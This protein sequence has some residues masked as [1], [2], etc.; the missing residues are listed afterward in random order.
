M[1]D[2]Y[3]YP[4]H[5]HGPLQICI[6]C[7]GPVFQCFTLGGGF[8]HTSNVTNPEGCQTGYYQNHPEYVVEPIPKS[9]MIETRFA[10]ESPE[11]VVVSE[12]VA[13]SEWNVGDVI[14]D[15]YEIKELIGQGGM[16]KVFKVRHR[17]WNLDLAV[18]SPRVEIFSKQEGKTGFVK[19]AQSWVDLG[20]Y[21]HIVTCYYVRTLGDIPRIF[22]E[23]IDGGSLADWIRS[24]RLYEGGNEKALAR[25][26]DFMIQFVLG[27]HYA[28]E[29]GLIHQDV[30]PANVMIAVDGT[31]KVTDFGLSK[32]RGQ[33]GENQDLRSGQSILVSS[34]GMTPAYCSPEQASG[35]Q[36]SR[37]TDIW[38]WGVSVLEIFTGGVN[39]A[40]GQV[41]YEALESYL[42]TGS[43]GMIPQMPGQLA[44]LLKLCFSRNP[45]D[46]PASMMNIADTLRE[47]YQQLTGVTYPRLEPKAATL[48]ADGLNNKAL[49][50]L[51]L[52]MESS[53]KEI[54]QSALQADPQHPE[55][56]YN[57]G[58]HNWRCGELADDAL[59]QR[60][61]SVQDAHRERWQPAYYT[62]LV[63]LE[64]CDPESAIPLLEA[65][66]RQAGEQPEI[67]AMLK[68]ATSGS[69]VSPR[70]LQKL[71]VHTDYVTS[72]CWSNDRTKIL[73]ASNDRYMKL[74]DLE[75]GE[76][77]RTFFADGDRIDSIS[78]TRDFRF[79][80]TGGEN[81]RV[82]LWDIQ[83]GRRLRTLS[84]HRMGIKAVDMTPDGHYGVS[85]SFESLRLW[86]I[87][88]GICKTTFPEFHNQIVRALAITPDGRWIVTGDN[89]NHFMTLWDGSSGRVVRKIEGLNRPASCLC[90][91]PDGRFVL[92]GIDDGTLQFWDLATG[93]RSHVFSG[94]TGEISSLSLSTD[95]RFALSGSYDK[96]LRLWDA[97]SGRCLRTIRNLGY[98]ELKCMNINEDC[99]RAVFAI[100]SHILHFSFPDITVHKSPFQVSRVWSHD[101][102]FESESLAARLI[103]SAKDA[104][105]SSD[106][107]SA[108]ES[109]REARGLSGHERSPQ[110]LEIWKDLTF[111]CKRSGLRD[112]WL[113]KSFEGHV[114][115]VSSVSLNRNARRMLSGC[116]VGSM[117]LWDTETGECFATYEKET[118]WPWI[119]TVCLSGD[120]TFA[121]FGGSQS[122]KVWLLDTLTKKGRKLGEHSSGLGSWVNSV[123]LSSD[124]S[125]ALSGGTDKTARLW[126]VKTGKCLR[127]F[128]HDDGIQHVCFSPDDRFA[129]TAAGEKNT[130]GYVNL[131]T[132]KFNCVFETDLR[133]W[134][135]ACF[136]KD[137][138]R[139]IVSGT[140]AGNMNPMIL[141]WDLAT[142]K[143]IQTIN[144]SG[145]HA[146]VTPD[147]KWILSAEGAAL[148][149]IQ[150][151]TGECIKEIEAHKS[152]ITS[153]CLSA[154][155]R[156]VATA[157]RDKTLRLWHLDWDLEAHKSDWKQEDSLPFI[158]SFL[159]LHTP[160]SAQI[161]GD[162]DPNDDEKARRL[163]RTGT[164]VWNDEDFSEFLR[165]M[166][167]AG[168]GFR[169]DNL[170]QYAQMRRLLIQSELA[171]AE[172]KW[173]DAL[174]LAKEARASAPYTRDPFCMNA[175]AAL[176]QYCRRTKFREG[177]METEWEGHT[178]PI[179][180]LQVSTY[181]GRALTGSDDNAARVWDLTSG[182]SWVFEKHSS[183]VCC[184]A[185][186]P[187]GLRALSGSSDGK[188]L[189]WEIETNKVVQQYANQEAVIRSAYFL[190]RGDQVLT[191]SDD[192]TLRLWETQTGDCTRI[193]KGHSGA[194][195]SVC[196]AADGR[197]ALSAGQ[198]R[199][200]RLW[201]LS[202]GK[203]IRVLN[204]H[205][206]P[207]RCVTLDPANR[208]A[209][210]AGDDKAVMVWDVFTGQ[211]LRTFSGHESAVASIQLTSDG[212]WLLSTGEDKTV[213][214][215]NTSSGDCVRVLT[216]SAAVSTV[217]LRPDACSM[218]LPGLN[219]GMQ[220]WRLDWDLELPAS[221]DWIEQARPYIESFLAQHSSKPGGLLSFGHKKPEW[222]EQDFDQLLFTLRCA[223]YG[224]ISADTI[225]L[226]LHE[227][228]ENWNPLPMPSGK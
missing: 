77:L 52:G 200:I 151:E 211:C 28:H 67:D 41:A 186:H 49:S 128:G 60:L 100:G 59:L 43:E 202:N 179:R 203:C 185:Y 195:Y 213:R 178:A 17:G 205:R 87:D 72:V 132:G 78:V 36:L 224:F 111:Q 191:A 146:V 175:W 184:V 183:P 12:E 182:K 97:K 63:H 166:G 138:R 192:S 208:L 1:S 142:R 55:T 10:T 131:A 119:K 180:A 38:S 214:L 177:W 95:G 68:T 149:V 81:G 42:E 94:H 93:R 193:L 172:K 123:S 66:L 5:D 98:G 113:L 160:Y 141:V 139:I 199:T 159:T 23:Y 115:E 125:L 124:G 155:G 71:E 215:W 57:S 58:V 73:S 190:R 45:D 31:V 150:L 51:D 9:P 32:A 62:G 227:F 133:N 99:T 163:T 37:K 206:G 189:L 20:I 153:L 135:S 137:G 167:A 171:S 56:V 145:I 207:V 4:G 70:V 181:G 96:S 222:T 130:I 147:G 168:V 61:D 220:F 88:A 46:R 204:G 187:D 69:I 226:K 154:D 3:H 109:I 29:K 188:L 221:Q 197:W 27:L 126:D 217:G 104:L 228:S 6:D 26:L 74:T 44:D 174:S 136:T 196:A 25:I 16:G 225:R 89:S 112:V 140:G 169:E 157:S 47:L 201:N 14:L 117:R 148:R 161:P 15:L 102:L 82:F 176:A 218:I 8:Y 105:K 165:H 22:A 92:A 39:W 110:N 173:P 143:C 194:V 116:D 76:V 114:R 19:E 156:S 129:L 24:E 64:R 152:W 223:G 158:E 101:V 144:D 34:G 91:S 65:A 198:D 106:F 48:M 30:K 216:L 85:S 79:A 107:A 120:G 212:K 210:S 80:L 83:T 13:L 33:A 127:I 164:P 35:K 121:L 2:L 40:S 162:R 50:F 75:S 90:L 103:Q 7:G 86:D 170:R 209:F 122:E 108:L 21:P 134:I 53:A 118:W 219:S 84:G 18:K 11:A 54:W